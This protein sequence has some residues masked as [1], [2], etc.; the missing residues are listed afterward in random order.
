MA[1]VREQVT[2]KRRRFLPSF[3]D[4]RFLA[5]RPTFDRVVFEMAEVRGEMS[6]LILCLLFSVFCLLAWYGWFRVL[7]ASSRQ[8]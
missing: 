3:S 4:C 5:F 6:E 1:D 8:R 7:T 2:E